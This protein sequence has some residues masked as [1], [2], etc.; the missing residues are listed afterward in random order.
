MARLT[1]RKAVEIA[2]RIA[3]DYELDLQDA[4]HND[5][6]DLGYQIA[7]R[8]IKAFRRVLKKYYEDGRSL[9]EIW[10]DDMRDEPTVDVMELY[11]KAQTNE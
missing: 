7:A 9:Q 10:A 1:D 6:D 4:V 11:R 3:I 5:K 8:R 2:L